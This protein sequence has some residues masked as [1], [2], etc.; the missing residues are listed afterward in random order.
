MKISVVYIDDDEAD[1]KKYKAKFE[2]DERAKG[3]FIIQPHGSPKT[4]EHY[5]SIEEAAPDL[6]LVDYDLSIPD[7]SGAV[8]GISGVTLT[9]ELRQSFPEI[10]IVLFTRKSVFKV[11]EYVRIKETLSSIDEIV[12][13]QDV[14]KKDSPEL[15]QLYQL[16]IGFR[17]LGRTKA[18]QWSE[19]LKLMEAPETD[20]NVLSLC[21]PPVLPK[22]GWAAAAMAAWVRKVVLKYPGILY[23]P[24]HAATFLGCSKAAFL[25][26]TLQEF[27]GPAR[28]SGIFLP[29]E[30]RWWKTKLQR[31]AVSVMREQERE[32]PLRIGFPTAWERAKRTQLQRAKCIFSGNDHPE[33]VCYILQQPV[34]MKYSLSYR[35]DRR[36]AVMDEARVSFEAVRTSNDFDQRLVDPLG[37][38]MIPEIRRLSKPVEKARVD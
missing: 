12:Y 25:S 27:F 29:H 17:K 6:F 1:L 14:F 2:T 20:S 23:D 10:P 24:I 31:V 11:Q 19:L 16:A 35:P 3:R 8:I 4:R 30:G 36:P 5:A 15:G 37:R 38:E 7:K 9:T 34:M 21:D 28:Y 13:K 18:G 22:Q 26:P 32:M 33:W